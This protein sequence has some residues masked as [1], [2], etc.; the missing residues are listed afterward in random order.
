MRVIHDAKPLLEDAE[1]AKTAGETQAFF[2]D[3]DGLR[4]QDWRT[5]VRRF[6]QLLTSKVQ[7]EVFLAWSPEYF[8]GTEMESIATVAK[9]ADWQLFQRPLA[10]AALAVEL[11]KLGRSAVGVG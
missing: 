4:G 8:S 9:T 3:L 6:I 7:P 2:L 10:V 5:V 11:Q 1:F